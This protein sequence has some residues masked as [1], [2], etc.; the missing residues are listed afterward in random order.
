MAV[1]LTTTNNANF[2][3][4]LTNSRIGVLNCTVCDFLLLYRTIGACGAFGITLLCARVVMLGDDS[5]NI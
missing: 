3:N 2:S 5:G 4:C 1:V